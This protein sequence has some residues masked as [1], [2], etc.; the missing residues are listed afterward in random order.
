MGHWILAVISASADVDSISRT[1][2]FNTLQ[3]NIMNVAFC[4]IEAEVVSVINLW[5][6]YATC[7]N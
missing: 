5:G 7:F 2:D 1:L 3:D 6:I 4:N